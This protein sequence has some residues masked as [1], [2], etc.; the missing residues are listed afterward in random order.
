MGKSWSRA[1]NETYARKMKKDKPNPPGLWI[2]FLIGFIIMTLLA[3]SYVLYYPK[4]SA[5]KNTDFKPTQTTTTWQPQNPKEYNL[6][7]DMNTLNNCKT[8]ETT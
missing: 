3:I 4:E 6:T 8:T 5:I 7:C 1:I 2:P